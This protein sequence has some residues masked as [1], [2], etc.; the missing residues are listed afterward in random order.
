[1]SV[2]D[3][4]F[5][6]KAPTPGS[7]AT[8]TQTQLPQWYTDYTTDMLGRA[9]GIANLPYA[10]Y[11]GP[12]IAGFTPTE[13]SGFEQTKAAAGAYQPFLNQAGAALGQ[14]GGMSGM[15]AAAGDFATA[16]GMQ[17]AKAAA[18]YLTQAAGMSALSTAQPMFTQALTPIQQAGQASALTAAQPFLGAA[19]RTFPQAAQEYMSP[20]LKNVVEQM[21]DIGVRQL[22]EKYLPAI[23]QE[24]IGAGQFS[25]GPGSTRM[26]EFGARALRDTQEAILA[27]QAKALQA[28]YGQAADIYGQDVGRLAQLAGTVGQLSTSDL[29]RMLE[30]GVRV[31]DIG[32]KM[33]Q[34]TSDD[35]SRIAEIGKATGQLTQQDAANLAR[36]GES[37]GQLTQ[38]DAQNLQNLASKYSMLGEAAQTMGL[39]GAQAVTGVGAKERAMQQANL[40]LA[41]QDFLNQEKYPKEQIKFLSDVLSGVQLPQ[42]T[43]TNTTTTPGQAGDPSLIAKLITGGKGAAD[44]IDMFKKYFPAKSDGTQYDYD[45]IYKDLLKLGG[46]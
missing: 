18:P 34:L 7:T 1:M 44:L 8:S 4:L 46:G 39:T 45:Q 9:Q 2:V 24:F 40:D 22:Q 30:S 3:F 5:G 27:E 20:Y 43:I 35:A 12:R 28:G 15:G 32:A 13:L 14:A 17:G 36:I 11:T 10:Q 42:T 23:G 16:A 33:G 26:G 6:G 21:G 37:K 25:V 29:N 41:Y 38:Q 19:S 31:A